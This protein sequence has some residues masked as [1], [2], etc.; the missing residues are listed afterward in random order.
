MKIDMPPPALAPGMPR[1]DD[2]PVFRAPWEAQA[3]AMTLALHER[4]LFSWPEW[5]TAL[6]AR[7]AQAQVE[8][9]AGR[10]GG[11]QGCRQRRR[12]AGLAARM[13]PRG[14]PHAARPGD[15]GDGCRLA[16]GA[17]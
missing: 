4:G 13:G 1:D 7:I 14:G 8:G 12:T 9:G 10:P 2:G 5:A 11:R 16:S 6:A 17:L 15:R 3:F